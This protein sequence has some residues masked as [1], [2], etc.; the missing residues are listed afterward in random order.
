MDEKR[1][2]G[3]PRREYP[4]VCGPYAHG[5]KWR[6]VIVRGRDRSGRTSDTETFEDRERAVRTKRELERQLAGTGK[7]VEGAVKAYLHSIERKGN[8]DGTVNAARWQLKQLLDFDMPLVD[9]N[10]RR[11]T[12]LYEAL[13][14]KDV[15]VDTH[16]NALAKGRSL[17]KFC[18]AQGWI[19]VNPFEGIEGVG[20]RKKG[21]EQLGFDETRAYEDACFKA[22][23]DTKDRGAAASLLALMFSMRASEVSQLL[24]R[25]VD[26][27]GRIL[28]IAETEA[29]TEASKRMAA[30]PTR[31]RPMLRDLAEAPA[32]AEGHLFAIDQGKNK[33]KPADRH[34]VLRNVRRLMKTA[35]VKVITAHGLRGTSATIGAAHAGA[36]VM[37][38][39]L[40]HT[41]ISMTKS[42]YIDADSAA[43]AQ[44]QKFADLLADSDD[45]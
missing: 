11:A 39:A 45:E 34:W 24:A 29:K 15:A 3:R 8:K 21:K 19:R 16:R 35:G 10:K 1:K 27:N 23:T 12:E 6:L 37:S 44:S 33:G 42:A 22:W 43:D 28:R 26:N 9:L 5:A 32:T 14:N 20:R 31:Y 13:V 2:P 17:G 40:G 41:T 38:E 36:K 18:V 25:D 4:Y 30:V 7:T